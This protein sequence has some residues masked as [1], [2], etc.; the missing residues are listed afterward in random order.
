[1]TKS[2]ENYRNDPATREWVAKQIEQKQQAIL[3][4]HALIREA[5]AK[6][7]GVPLHNLNDPIYGR[8]VQSVKSSLHETNHLLGSFY[9]EPST[10]TYI[11]NMSAFEVGVEA[12]KQGL[13]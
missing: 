1:M 6:L 7:T 11:G 12:N 5:Y 8:V 9:M 13:V 4:A 10:E 2:N 3:E